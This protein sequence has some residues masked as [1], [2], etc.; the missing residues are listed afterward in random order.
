MFPAHGKISLQIHERILIAEVEGPWN[1]ELIY[2]YQAMMQPAV[3]ELSD[4]GSWGLIVVIRNEALCPPEAVAAIHK[5]VEIQARR[6]SRAC[7]A[8][9][10]SPNVE[11][12]HI[13]DN[14]WRSIYSPS[15]SFE[16]FESLEDAMQWTKMTIENCKV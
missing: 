13:L 12:Y 14:I 9:V 11:G 15:F 3:E 2:K 6:Y 4:N 1:E 7:T 5:G 8:Y 10:I 16:I